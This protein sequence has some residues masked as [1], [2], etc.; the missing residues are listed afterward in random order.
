[1]LCCSKSSLHSRVLESSGT[2]RNTK[3]P[4]DHWKA[5]ISIL[6]KLANVR[7]KV[8]PLHVWHKITNVNKTKASAWLSFDNLDI[9]TF[10]SMPKLMVFNVEEILRPVGK[11]L[12]GCQDQYYDYKVLREIL[13]WIFHWPTGLAKHDDRSEVQLC[14][15]HILAAS[16]RGYQNMQSLL[17]C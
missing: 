5:M 13:V 10:D 4:S 6:L 3:K 17:K 15:L 9:I 14:T 1:M 7:F 11:P 16:S 2:I 8:D 12:V